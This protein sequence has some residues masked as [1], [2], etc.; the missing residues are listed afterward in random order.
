VGASFTGWPRRKLAA[1][2]GQSLRVILR[3]TFLPPDWWLRI[4]YAPTGRLGRL[5]VLLF[6]HPRH[7]FWWVN[8]Y[9]GVFLQAALPEEN[10][11]APMKLGEIGAV[12]RNCGKVVAAMYRK[13]LK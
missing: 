6:K 3:D 13:I 2:K 1:L 9:W 4:Y 7:V 11:S 5:R 8:L 10:M 12:M